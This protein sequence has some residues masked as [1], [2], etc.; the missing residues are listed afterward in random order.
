[1]GNSLQSKTLNNFNKL[2]CPNILGI[3]TLI[4]LSGNSICM[5]FI[6]QEK[7]LLKIFLAIRFSKKIKSKFSFIQV[8]VGSS[9]KKNQK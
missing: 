9:Q 5:G 4:V 8:I 7:N 1:M 6:N 2:Y 3:G